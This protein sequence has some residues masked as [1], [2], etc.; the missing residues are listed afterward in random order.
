MTIIVT[1]IILATTL[2]PLAHAGEQSVNLDTITVSHMRVET[3]VSKILRPSIKLKTSKAAWNKISGKRDSII[4]AETIA[5]AG[6][7]AIP[8]IAAAIL[9]DTIIGIFTVPYDVLATPF[10]MEH[11]ITSGLWTVSGQITDQLKRPVEGMPLQVRVSIMQSS[12]T[13][14]RSDGLA[15]VVSNQQGW[16]LTEIQ[17]SRHVKGTERMAIEIQTPQ[18]NDV[19]TTLR[20]AECPVSSDS[21]EGA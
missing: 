4:P 14:W 8:I 19:L 16:F 15:S 10:R 1:A 2:N 6:G 3:R 18:Q 7:W 9:T 21:C 12:E 20:R 13:E 5:W 11:K 17:W